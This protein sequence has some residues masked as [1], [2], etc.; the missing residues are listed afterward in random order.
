MHEREG[1]ERGWEG[2]DRKGSKKREMER[3][4]EKGA[5]RG[6]GSGLVKG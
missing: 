5:R 1:A 3:K 2:W 4:D 6:A